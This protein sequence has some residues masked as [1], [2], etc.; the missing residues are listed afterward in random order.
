MVSETSSHRYGDYPIFVDVISEPK[1][2]VMRDFGASLC[3]ASPSYTILEGKTELL[4]DA[5][6]S[7]MEYPRP[8]TVA[9]S[10]LDFG[11]NHVSWSHHR[12]LGNIGQ[13][14]VQTKRFEPQKEMIDLRLGRRQVN[15]I[16]LDRKQ[17]SELILEGLRQDG[18]LHR[19][20]GVAFSIHF[21]DEPKLL[22]PVMIKPQ[23]WMTFDHRRQQD[24]VNTRANTI[25]DRANQC[26]DKRDR[27]LER[28]L[29]S[30]HR[31][32]ISTE[33]QKEEKV[34]KTIRLNE[35]KRRKAA[36]EARR[37][38]E[39]SHGSTTRVKAMEQSVQQQI[40]T[41]RLKNNKSKRDL[42]NKR[43]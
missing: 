6:E 12:T 26:S 21:C 4:L 25:I 28:L 10:A 16:E 15:D 36:M 27:I 8:K 2:Q 13:N 23:N 43:N 20:G 35:K 7:Q 42:K 39:L 5:E 22:P 19:R 17:K 1:Q 18:Y 41:P 3:K 38:S 33:R 29:R 31:A 9:N 14:A 34:D 11:G 37:Q 30:S 40:S 32:N 24:R